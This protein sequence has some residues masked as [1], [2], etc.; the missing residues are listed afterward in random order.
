MRRH[1]NGRSN[2]GD[3]ELAKF[4]IEHW[5]QLEFEPIADGSYGKDEVLS[6]LTLRVPLP[7]LEEYWSQHPGKYKQL[8]MK[9]FLQST[10]GSQRAFEKA[11][12]EKAAAE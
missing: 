11:E 2:F 3:P 6:F 9:P 12:E 7:L 1:S 8:R 4:V 5:D 10:Y